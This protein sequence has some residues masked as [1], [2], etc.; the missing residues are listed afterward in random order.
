VSKHLVVADHN[1]PYVQI[2]P[3]SVAA[4]PEN[5]SGVKLDSPHAIFWSLWLLPPTPNVFKG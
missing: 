2:N 5:K 1:G 4:S 3:N